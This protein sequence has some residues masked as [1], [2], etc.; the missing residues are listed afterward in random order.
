MIELNDRKNKASLCFTIDVEDWFHI[1]ESPAVPNIEQW[2]CLESCVERNL[3]KLLALLDSVSANCTLFWLGWVA[4]RH[5][6][7]VRACQVAGHEIACHGY[8]HVLAN[9]VGQEAFREDIRQSKAIL[10]DITGEPVRGFRAP[11][12]GVTRKTAWAFDVIREVGYQ[13]DASV[14][15]AYRG[16]VGM[17]D[18]PLGLHFIETRSGHLLEIP[19]SVVEI[20]GRRACLFGGGYLRLATKPMIKWGLDRLLAADQPLV[21]YVHPREIDPSH[22]RLPLSL[23]R[24]FKCYVGL[25]STMSKLEWLC[26]DYRPC[27]MLDTIESCMKSFYHQARTLPVV[28]LRSGHKAT[29][30]KFAGGAMARGGRQPLRDRLLQVEEAMATFIG[31]AA[32]KLSVSEETQFQ[33]S[34]R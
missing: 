7:L 21:V 27:S 30:A 8:G 20:F 29:V 15:P 31:P 14:F 3:E 11:G 6:A 12:F 19:L 28:N 18:A 5:K 22:P 32:M 34:H 25:K 10:E 33:T 26:R 23:K 13:Y 9:Q 4:E 2:S 17:A 1:L 16:H 24:R